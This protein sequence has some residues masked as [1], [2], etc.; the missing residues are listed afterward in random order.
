[1]FFADE[2]SPI[3]A[4]GSRP[5]KKP[6][7]CPSPLQAIGEPS[8]QIPLRRLHPFQALQ[9]QG[10]SR[11]IAISV[12]R[13]E[14]HP[15]LLKQSQRHLS[16][17]GRLSVAITRSLLPLQSKTPLVAGVDVVSCLRLIQTSSRPVSALP[18]MVLLGESS[19]LQSP[20]GQ[21][22]GAL[23]HSKNWVQCNLFRPPAVLLHRKQ[24]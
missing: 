5:A 1:M 12:I 22:Q 16:F 23:T 7:A 21:H 14:C 17:E 2:L 8:S 20:V 19:S 9:C 10:Q 3:S 18:R 13:S 4:R 24:R 11:L 6:S 15:Q